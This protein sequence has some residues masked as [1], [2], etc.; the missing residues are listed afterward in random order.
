VDVRTIKRIAA[1]RARAVAPCPCT[2][3]A[4]W[5]RVEVSVFPLR[6]RADRSLPLAP[7]FEPIRANAGYI[8]PCSMRSFACVCGSVCVGG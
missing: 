6:K 1:S 8:I 5:K 2:T 7:R 3:P 4:S